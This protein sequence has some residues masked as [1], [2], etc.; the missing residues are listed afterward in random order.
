MRCFVCSSC[1]KELMPGEQFGFYDGK[2]FCKSDFDLFQQDC[3]DS[4]SGKGTL[5]NT[6]VLAHSFSEIAVCFVLLWRGFC[7]LLL[8]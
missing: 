6:N 8:G 5:A 7:E 1:E 2:L 3:L 4:T